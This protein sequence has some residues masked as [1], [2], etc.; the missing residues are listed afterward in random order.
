MLLLT[1]GSATDPSYP[2][3]SVL[4]WLPFPSSA[5]KHY[6]AFISFR[7]K[8][9]LLL[10]EYL[11]VLKMVLW[12][13][14]LG[15]ILLLCGKHLFTLQGCHWNLEILLYMK[16]CWGKANYLSKLPGTVLSPLF[17]IL[18]TGWCHSFELKE[19]P[20]YVGME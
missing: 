16:Q 20:L 13:G 8:M 1:I 9:E 15:V 14:D 12:L 19:A 18:G 3:P 6:W 10:M 11:N 5:N 17:L 7:V 2:S 4:S